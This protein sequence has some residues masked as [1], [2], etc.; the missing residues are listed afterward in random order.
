MKAEIG[1]IKYYNL[2]PGDIIV[3]PKSLFNLIQHH[4]VY[5]GY[6]NFGNHFISENVIGKGVVLTRVQDFFKENVVITRIEKFEGSYFER[7]KVVRRA[8]KNLGRPY[9]LINYNCEHFTNE[10]IYSK[11]NSPQ[12]MNAFGVLTIFVFTILF[13][14]NIEL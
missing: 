9:D 6:D 14:K 5:L 10:T 2:K 3:T 4:A 7:E 1:L 11:P 12:V 8:L 13:F